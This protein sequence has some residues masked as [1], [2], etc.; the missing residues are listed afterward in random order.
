MNS[1]VVFI[2]IALPVDFARTKTNCVVDREIWEE[3][4][5]FLH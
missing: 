3:L 1:D 5:S 2:K 4:F